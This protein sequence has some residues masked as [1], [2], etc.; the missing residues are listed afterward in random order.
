[1]HPCCHRIKLTCVSLAVLLLFFLHPC[2][3]N[4]APGKKNDK[5]PADKP[6]IIFIFAD[7]MAWSDVSYKG[8]KNADFY[9]TTNIDR[10][11][12]EGMVLN[13][14]YPS[15][16]N[17]APTRASLLTGMYTPRHSVY[18]P[19]GYSRGGAIH[20]MRFKTPTHGADDS[21]MESFHVSVNQVSPEFESLAE[22]LKRAGYVSARLGKWHIGDD[23]QGFDLSS[24][25]GTPNYITNIHG[26]EHRFYT[27]VTVAERLT[28]A[29]IDFMHQHRN[30]PF[31]L[32]LSH[33]EPHLPLAAREDR[34]V[35][36]AKKLG[37]E[38]EGDFTP[39][40]YEELR[41]NT[42][43]YNPAV[44]AAMLEQ[45]DISTKRVL[46][47][48]EA[49]GLEEN[50]MVIFSS[51]NGGLSDYTSNYPLR[52]GKGTYYE[53]GIRTPFAV[54]WPAVIEPGSVSDIAV[55]GVDLMPTF[56]EMASVDPPGSQPVDG[57]S[58]MP[59][60]KGEEDAFDHDRSM[61]FHFP[62]YIGGNWIDNVLPV[63]NGPENYWR[64]VPL[65]V[66]MKGDYKLIYYYEYERYELFNLR[67]DISE[68]N[69]LADTQP[70][71]AQSL[72]NELMQWVEEVDAPVPNIPN[73]FFD[74]G[75][76]R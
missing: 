2:F 70:L 11:A 8:L 67:D 60:L 73:P 14:F 32:Y 44:Y 30:Q 51:D 9:Q 41:Q 55:N 65:S 24:A 23:N 6:N 66:I 43:Y 58:I 5:K 47:A 16:A 57:L 28:N 76:G 18:I 63:Y 12:A 36:F 69:D 33:W 4:A 38:T 26:Q 61:F 21:F 50:T 13:R 74:P 72:F 34:I 59:I 10:L 40:E 46:A 45:L 27:D 7:D 64:G 15:A 54:R 1:M 35:H 22:M 37:Y 31:F 53:G 48:L 56:A 75:Q 25:D 62:L 20:N 42:E 39:E 49:L 19:Q 17:C 52:A 68:Q 3:A 71:L 29:A